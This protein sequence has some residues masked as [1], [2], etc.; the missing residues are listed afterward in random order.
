[1]RTNN[2]SGPNPGASIEEE[3]ETLCSA[4]LASNDWGRERTMSTALR[5]AEEVQQGSG[6]PLRLVAGAGLDQEAHFLDDRANLLPLKI[7]R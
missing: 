3:L 6:S 7:V 4:Y 1:M 2:Q 5:H